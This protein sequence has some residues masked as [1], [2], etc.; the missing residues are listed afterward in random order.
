MIIQ[1]DDNEGQVCLITHLCVLMGCITGFED[2]ALFRCP[3]PRKAKFSRGEIPVPRG[4]FPL[5]QDLAETITEGHYMLFQYSN[6]GFIHRY[7]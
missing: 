6:A 5:R 7:T 3:D 4:A 2:V 1:L